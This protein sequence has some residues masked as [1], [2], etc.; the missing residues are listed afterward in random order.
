[1]YERDSTISISAEENFIEKSENHV[2]ENNILLSPVGAGG[3]SLKNGM[4]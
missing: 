3:A 4:T 1:M 2:G